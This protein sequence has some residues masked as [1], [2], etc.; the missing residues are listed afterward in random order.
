MGSL[1]PL[2]GSIS[3]V[4]LS[5][6]ILAIIAPDI[7]AKIVKRPVKRISVLKFV[8]LPAF[9]VFIIAVSITPDSSK[10]EAP[11]KK[12][13]E[14]S[15]PAQHDASSSQAAEPELKGREAGA[16]LSKYVARVQSAISLQDG[17]R[18]IQMSQIK[19]AIQFG[20]LDKYKQAAQDMKETT[21][22]A[23]EDINAIDPP[24]VGDA[25]ATFVGR[26]YES[27]QDIMDVQVDLAVDIA[28]QADTGMDM[29]THAEVADL[30]A[31]KAKADAKLKASIRAAY[32]HF[33]YKQSEIN[34][35]TLRIKGM[36]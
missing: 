9:I 7:A 1:A 15:A 22:K 23:R 16:V 19:Q 34:M 18:Q 26:V 20:D 17:V 21:I 30:K 24:D 5:V 25:D 4:T 32:E 12:N 35:K 31:R 6:S 36:D 10:T 28:A 29:L 8:M 13:A 11:A 2:L 3:T 14:A 33:G 27:F